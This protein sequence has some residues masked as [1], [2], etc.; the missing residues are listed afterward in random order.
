MRNKAV[1][2]ISSPASG[3]LTLSVCQS[4][5]YDKKKSV[6]L[7]SFLSERKREIG[8]IHRESERERPRKFYRYEEED[9]NYH[10]RLPE[11]GVSEILLKNYK[12]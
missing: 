12:Q 9:A 4:K 1:V 8:R 10:V 5:K 11:N 7:F 6:L 3:R 2:K